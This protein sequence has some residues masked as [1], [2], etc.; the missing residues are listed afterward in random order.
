MPTEA[1]R[2]EA[3]SSQDVKNTALLIPCV[4]VIVVQ[5]ASTSPIPVLCITRYRQSTRPRK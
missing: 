4:S 5:V 3:M 2:V 1:E